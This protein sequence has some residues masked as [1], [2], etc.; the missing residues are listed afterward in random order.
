LLSI[1]NLGIFFQ[2][3][4]LYD[5]IASI[6]ILLIAFVALIP[7]LRNDLPPTTKVVFIEYLVY[8]QT[9]TSILALA[10][11]MSIM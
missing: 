6:S 8:F 5:R 10:H 2:N 4:D 11:S 7:T 9:Y 3:W 1:I